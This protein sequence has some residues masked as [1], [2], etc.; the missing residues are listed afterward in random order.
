MKGLVSHGRLT[1]NEGLKA[2]MKRPDG[3]RSQ[4]H[5]AK[6]VLSTLLTRTFGEG[7]CVF[8]PL[9]LWGV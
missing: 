1:A 8:W 5:T 3:G 2:K 6:Y 4:Q 7:L 9:V